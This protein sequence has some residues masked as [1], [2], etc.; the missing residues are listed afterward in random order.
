[1][2]FGGER[3]LSEVRTTPV[4]RTSPPKEG[5]FVNAVT[6]GITARS[7]REVASS[8]RKTP[9]PLTLALSPQRVERVLYDNRRDGS[10][11]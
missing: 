4:L 1:L 8:K 11:G 9:S 2:S 5:N 10:C 6:A 3:R 7:A